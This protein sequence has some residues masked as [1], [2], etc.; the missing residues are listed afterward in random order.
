MTM[1]PRR[2]LTVALVL[3]VG[4]LTGCSGDPG[5]RAVTPAT[6]TTT[7]AAPSSTSVAPTAPPTTATT[8]SLRAAT[9]HPRAPAPIARQEVASASLDGKVWVIGGLTSAGASNVVESYDP[10]TDRWAPGPS[11][12]LAVH[13]AAATVYRGEIVVLGGFVEAGTLYAQAT[14]RAFAL[15]N[16]AWVELPHLRRPRG[17]AAAA[18]VGDAL[19]L[20]GGRDAAILIGPTEVFD[21]TAW[22]DAEPV[23]TRRDHL[24]AVSDGRS[25]F[26]VGGRFL[27]PGA[28]S[29]ALERFDPAANAWE[30]LPAMP[31]ARGG[32]AA[33]MVGGRIV[34]AGGEDPTGT[35]AQVEAFDVAAGAWSSLAPLSTPRH[36]L[37]VERVGN[38]VLAL[39]GGT[40]YGVAPSKVAE[41]LS[42]VS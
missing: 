27:S 42:P 29:G 37:A 10:A 32:L 4:G 23:P 22:H 31:T 12:P 20:V 39:V 14:D 17:A 36:G 8:V 6:S 33:A 13:H 25:V 21:G 15:R 1:G 16:G 9:W 26:A 5:P 24:A 35:F 30:R 11:L 38:Q 19:V 40:A 34:A 2:G 18:V 3:V 28:T 41:A 7:G